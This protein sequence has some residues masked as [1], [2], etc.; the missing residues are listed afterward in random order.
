MYNLDDQCGLPVGDKLAAMLNKMTRS[1]LSEE[2]LSEKLNKYSRPQNCET[3][4]ELRLTL[5]FGLKH[6][7]RPG[8]VTSRCKTNPEH[9]FESN[10][11]TFNTALKKC[12]DCSV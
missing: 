11:T 10:N 6:S 4:W 12:F 3:L 7:Q 9:N 5:K 8:A 2:K 1:K